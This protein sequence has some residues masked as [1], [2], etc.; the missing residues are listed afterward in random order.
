MYYKY[1]EVYL[2]FQNA[3]LDIFSPISRFMVAVFQ[4]IDVGTDVWY[5]K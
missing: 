1:F 5:S 4:K 3:I 2:Y